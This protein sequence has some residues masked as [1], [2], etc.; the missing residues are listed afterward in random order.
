[1]TENQTFVYENNEVVKTG[2]T[3]KKNLTSG[4]V[5]VLFEITPKDQTLGTWKKWVRDA[6][7]FTVQP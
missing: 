4:K 6:D 7:L 2:R 1:M 3:A 5:D